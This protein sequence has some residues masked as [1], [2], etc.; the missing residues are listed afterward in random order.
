MENHLH[1]WQPI[2]PHT[3]TPW[4]H[5]A[6]EL[7]TEFRDRRPIALSSLFVMPLLYINVCLFKGT[8]NIRESPLFV[9]TGP[10]PWQMAERSSGNFFKHHFFFS[11]EISFQKVTGKGWGIKKNLRSTGVVG[12]LENCELV[13]VFLCLVVRGDGFWG[14]G[15][16]LDFVWLIDLVTICWRAVIVLRWSVGDW[17]EICCH[18][19]IDSKRTSTFIVINILLIVLEGVFRNRK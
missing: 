18:T 17:Y 9:S 10:S 8:D 2:P 7:V 4:R 5:V 3:W 12:E 1:F 15:L 16:V 19:G 14:V 6:L 11:L 13:F